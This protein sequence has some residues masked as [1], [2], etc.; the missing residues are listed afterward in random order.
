M[1]DTHDRAERRLRAADPAGPSRP[2]PPSRVPRAQ[3]IEDIMTTTEQSPTAP[4]AAPK[5]ART[6]WLLAAAA[7]VVAAAI[8]TTVALT[9]GGD[10]H[11]AAAQKTVA[12][13]KLPTAG[14]PLGTC[15]RFSVDLLRDEPVAFSGTVTAVS[16]GDVRLDVDHW[17]KGGSADQVE[18]AGRTT[19]DVVLEGGVNFQVG[20]RYLV[21]ARDGIVAGCGYTALW[22]TQMEQAFEQAFGS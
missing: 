17:F 15:I 11:P 7:A 19:P 14:G 2:L 16:D 12:H 21:S 10:S 6:R 5:P 3:L 13:L 4:P 1:S 20:E 8:G 18:L 9:A 22:S